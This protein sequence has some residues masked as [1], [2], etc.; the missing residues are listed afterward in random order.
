MMKSTTNLPATESGQ[1]QSSC[2]RGD[3]IDQS[4]NS[5]ACRESDE[6]STDTE[7]GTDAET[8]AYN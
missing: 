8:D 4:Y 5:S 7:N 6:Q 3:L 2:S 1:N